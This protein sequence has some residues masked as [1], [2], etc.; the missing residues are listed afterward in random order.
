[1]IST[2]TNFFVISASLKFPKYLKNTYLLP[3]FVIF[4]GSLKNSDLGSKSNYLY[5]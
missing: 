3:G 5:A 4:M 2:S 1:M